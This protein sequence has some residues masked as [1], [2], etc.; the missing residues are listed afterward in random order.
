MEQRNR[1]QPPSDNDAHTIVEL[2]IAAMTNADRERLRGQLRERRKRSFRLI[3]GG[4]I[5]ALIAFL[6][7]ASV[8]AIRVIRHHIFATSV[9]SVT[10]TAVVATSVWVT[11]YDGPAQAAVAPSVT[12]E[13]VAVPIAPTPTPTRSTESASLGPIGNPTRPARGP[14]RVALPTPPPPTPVAR[15][16]KPR[17][18]PGDA[19]TSDAQEPSPEPRPTLRIPERKIPR[20]PLPS[21]APEL[22]EEPDPLPSP[23]PSLEVPLPDPVPTILDGVCELPLDAVCDLL[24]E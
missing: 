13:R 9:L 24:G 6:G 16:P 10:A 17:R 23:L 19:P 11:P 21:P 4:K 15:P 18:P 1:D 3:E 5:I 14:A 20:P 2:L 7:G 22:P 8:G 12:V